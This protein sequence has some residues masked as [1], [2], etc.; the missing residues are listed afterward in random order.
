MP[1]EIVHWHIVDKAL[2]L[3]SSNSQVISKAITFPALLYLGAM[4]PD[5]LYYH[6]FGCDEVSNALGEQLHGGNGEDTLLIIRQPLNLLKTL[7]GS[8]QDVGLTFIAGYLSHCAV[9]IT[10]HPWIFFETGDYYHPDPHARVLARTA[11]RIFEVYLD[12]W[13]RVHR[14]CKCDFRVASHL[15]SVGSHLEQISQLFGEASAVFST[16]EMTVE[17]ING[18]ARWR[19]SLRDMAVQQGRFISNSW[20]RALAA[21]N[22]ITGG[23]LQSIEA[24]SSFRR[25]EALDYFSGALKYKN[26]VT[27]ESFSADMQQLIDAATKLTCEYWQKLDRCISGEDAA[28]V[29]SEPGAS[30][31]YG[32]PGAHHSL[33][34]NYSEHHLRWRSL[35]DG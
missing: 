19:A 17:T 31:N 10:F 21:L 28:I 16:E 30:L 1:R 4:A 33:A 15:N 8:Q 32:L 26:P 18:A 24:L 7:V 20:G 12:S 5:A 23:K 27:G 29:F 9:D 34:R 3:G 6:R 11:H 35:R 13:F 25:R 2:E 22:V 14:P